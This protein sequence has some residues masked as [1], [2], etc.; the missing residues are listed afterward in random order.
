M[1]GA[2]VI[3]ASRGV[4]VTA[5]GDPAITAEQETVLG[6][7]RDALAAPPPDAP[8][9]DVMS[10]AVPSGADSAASVPRIVPARTGENPLSAARAD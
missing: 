4:I 2:L 7:M 10:T 9:Y 3:N 5:P 1:T 6:F 8:T